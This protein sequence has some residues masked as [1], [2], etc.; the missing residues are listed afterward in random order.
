MTN[1]TSPAT[2][3]PTATASSIRFIAERAIGRA[4]RRGVA[5]RRAQGCVTLGPEEL[6]D[7]DSRSGRWLGW[8]SCTS[9][10]ASCAAVADRVTVVLWPAGSS[11]F[12]LSSTV[13]ALA[14]SP[15][16]TG[17]GARSVWTGGDGFAGSGDPCI[18][19]GGWCAP[20]S[21]GS[22]RFPTGS[23]RSACLVAGN[24]RDSLRPAAHSCQSSRVHWRIGLFSS[25]ARSSTFDPAETSV[26][27]EA[28]CRSSVIRPWQ[29]LCGKARQR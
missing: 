25:W 26:L 4:G 21:D 6:G 16:S 18:G 28:W 2:R 1:V 10:G 19:S 5:G 3:A 8:R 23:D 17:S 24:L 22:G 14:A 9:E 13:S 20:G 27:S 12:A 15:A 7:A 29:A 11:T